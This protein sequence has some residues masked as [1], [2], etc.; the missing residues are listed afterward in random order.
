MVLSWMANDNIR[1]SEYLALNANVN[2]SHTSLANMIQ[3]LSQ[4]IDLQ[5]M[6]SGNS[7]GQETNHIHV[8]LRTLKV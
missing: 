1:N 6:S 2:R 4:F 7:L 3:R 8:A 5:E